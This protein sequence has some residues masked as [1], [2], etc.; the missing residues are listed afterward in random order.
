GAAVRKHVAHAPRI[1]L[2][3]GG[4]HVEVP[5]PLR[6]LGSQDVALERAASLHDSSRRHAEPLGGGLLG[7]HLR[8]RTSPMRR[9]AWARPCP[10]ARLTGRVSGPD[11]TISSAPGSCRETVLPG[12]ARS[13]P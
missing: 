2:A 5:L 10:P 4:F 12:A 3:D 13:P 6:G 7:L 8:H 9:G 11:R 1:R